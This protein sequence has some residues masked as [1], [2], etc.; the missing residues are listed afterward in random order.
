MGF[1]GNLSTLSL[2][3]VF[4]TINRIRA[5]G[6][7]HL[8]S[9][10]A[11]RE[12]AFS[13]GEIIGVAFRSGEERQ[14]LLRR[15]I[16]QGK[17]DATSAAAISTS[18]GKDSRVVIDALI[19][20]GM[21]KAEEVDEAVA[22]QSED[23]LYNLCTWEYA[24]FIFHDAAPE[25][26]EVVALVDHFKKRPLQL[27]VNKM[28]MEAARRLD[29]WGRL[30]EK[31]AREDVVLG[32]TAGREAD[33]LGASREYPGSAVVPLI[34]AVRTIEDIVRD[35]VATRLDVYGVVADIIE[36]G[37]VSVLSREDVL[38]HAEH[39][40]EH[41][42]HIRAAHLYRR[43]LAEQPKDRATF[44]KL[45]DCLEQLGD[46]PE[47]ASSF[48]QLALGYL[49][50]EGNGDEA[51]AAG[52][53]AVSLAPDDPR[54]R[55]ILVR[56][57]LET[58]DQ[59]EAISELRAVVA[60]YLA[61]GQLQ[62]ARGTCL[63]ILE[64]DPK[65]DDARRELARIFAKAEKDPD[66][67][68][69][70]VCV[71]CGQVN[72]RE[73]ETCT[74]CKAPLRLTCQGCSRTVAV[75]DRLCIFCGVDPHAGVL[76]QRAG[77][78]ATSRIIDPARV[79]QALDGRQGTESWRT[80]MD[81]SI[82]TARALEEKGDVIGALK[83]WRELAKIQ[84]DNA[85]LQAHIRSL[86]ARAGSAL[87]EQT[88]ERGH[89]L[90]RGRRFRGAISAYQAALRTMSES[91][92]RA[93]RLREILT[94]TT[95]TWRKVSAVYLAAG[96]ILLAVGG[97]VAQP[98]VQVHRFRGALALAAAE[99]PSLDA[100][101]PAAALPPLLALGARLDD[102]AARAQALG[103]SAGAGQARIEVAEAQGQLDLARSRL[104]ERA[105]AAA[106]QA[107]E[108]GDLQGASAQLG[109]IRAAFGASFGA[110]RYQA[111]NDRLTALRGQ[112]ETQDK[113]R[114]E[115]PARLALAKQKEKAGAP[116]EALA[117]YQALPASG[118]P[119]LVAE[120]KAAVLRLA[121]KQAEV[122][123]AIAQAAALADQDLVKAD[124]AL[125]ALAAPA[126]AWS[127]GDELAGARAP[128]GAHLA[129]AAAAFKALGAGPAQA[130][131]EAF[132]AANA[133]APQ[134]IQVR[135]RLDQL[136]QFQRSRDEQI[137]AYR[138]FMAAKRYDQAWTVTSALVADG[139]ALPAEVQLPLLVESDPPGA[140]VAL[141]G[142]VRGRTPCLLMF[143]AALR[144]G[145]DAGGISVALPGWQPLQRPA[146]ELLGDWRFQARLVRAP[147]WRA[148]LGKPVTLL[149]PRQGGGLL[150]LAGDA[151][152]ALDGDGGKRWSSGVAG[153]S[154]LSDA[155]HFHLSHAPLALP[156]GGVALG[157]PEGGLVRVDAQGVVGVRLESTA[158]VRGR[159]VLY[160]NDILGGHPRLAWAAEA[161][162]CGDLGAES[163]RIPLPSPALS[164]PL[165]MPKDLDRMLVVATNQGRLLAFEES[166]RRK[167]WEFDLK[168]A[169]CGQLVPAG[170]DLVLT[171]LDGSRLACYQVTPA[172]A[173]LRWTVTLGAPAVGEPVVLGRDIYVAAGAAILRYG[174]DGAAAAPLPLPA[175]AS[176]SVAA[177]GELVAAGCRNGALVVFRRLAPVWSSTCDAVPGA[178]AIDGAGIIC[179]LADGSL[180]AFSP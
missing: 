62:D 116:G 113:A 174:M 46:I 125:A 94:T 106:Q 151:L 121:P 10:E 44:G 61:L 178:V 77:S 30:R 176:T 45:A 42:D 8:A 81:D 68:D 91:D 138:Q 11:G 135:L 171:V 26:T 85:D 55:L 122:R 149:E 15:L 7:L 109:A 162:V 146:A 167:L 50:E 59:A 111:L 56:C 132:L 4:Q 145:G 72:H 2:V 168:I 112:R 137:A 63:K 102:L 88:I 37:L 159:P 87:T 141:E 38:A 103:R 47:A 95:R 173:A 169:E 143:P 51:V 117:I 33:L 3:E 104:G 29:E 119:A 74:S 107:M 57:L 152:V 34:D 93:T 161:L 172:G 144:R 89:Q 115:A 155:A 110:S 97:L 127:L 164:G 83:E 100:L 150:A 175:P 131:L 18:G 133:A 16:L 170:G 17:I 126:G 76:R 52:L 154:E 139:G 86:E 5:T 156:D 92:P 54:Q 20:R 23:E 180:L 179:G 14:A 71:Q 69:V 28:L 158:P 66:S 73:A 48:A 98:F 49:E 70:V 41:G 27:G 1:A 120:A 43:A 64:L 80:R 60:R 96:L 140:D 12:V 24:D 75:S 82:K 114:Q 148:A 32:A 105:F 129:A 136:R 157:L 35:S 134:A 99:L 165:A 153:A 90:R 53:R 58:G 142:Q 31:V 124:S 128:V 118:V 163:V 79:R 160:A 13:E 40:A 84:I 123:A 78:P 39:L 9:A 22:R 6:V 130:D 166:T 108:A 19:Q 67:E 36:D 21:I 25:N 101:P 65:D 147:R 177:A